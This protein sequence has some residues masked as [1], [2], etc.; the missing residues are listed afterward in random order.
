MLDKYW[1]VL[2][3]QSSI[4][5]DVI[6]MIRNRISVVSIKRL[7]ILRILLYLVFFIFK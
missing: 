7:Y 1:H 5:K 3:M 2:N 4:H 6:I